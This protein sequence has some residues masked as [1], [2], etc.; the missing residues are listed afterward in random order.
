MSLSIYFE[1]EDIIDQ[2][3]SYFDVEEQWTIDFESLLS[4]VEDASDEY[5]TLQI[6]DKLF[7]IYKSTGVV[8]EVV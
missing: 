7:K 2:I 1:D 8:E 4:Q 6:K 3:R 5:Y